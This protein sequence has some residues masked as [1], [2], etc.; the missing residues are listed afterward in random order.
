MKKKLIIVFIILLFSV[1]FHFCNKPGKIDLGNFPDTWYFLEVQ[2]HTG[3]AVFNLSCNGE[4]SNI[5]IKNVNDSYQ[6]IITDLGELIEQYEIRSFGLND[7]NTG[8]MEVRDPDREKHVLTF[9]FPADDHYVFNF[10]SSSEKPLPVIASWSLDDMVMGWYVADQM[11]DVIEKI[12]PPCLECF[13]FDECL[14][15]ISNPEKYIEMIN[16]AIDRSFDG[17]TVKEKTETD[18]DGFSGTDY[19]V[20]YWKGE[21]VKVISSY[22]AGVYATELD[23]FYI[24]NKNL[25]ASRHSYNTRPMMEDEKMTQE[26]SK[27]YYRNGMPLKVERKYVEYMP[28]PGENFDP[29]LSLPGFDEAIF[30]SIEFNPDVIGKTMDRKW[31]KAEFRVRGSDDND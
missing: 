9:E 5:E 19:R 14:V 26:E 6:L 31:R 1:P 8:M 24:K 30:N 3:N 2:D 27:I 28:E 20:Y 13:D 7:D 16:H 11:P 21:A 4:S 18:M 17:I 23:V 15:R 12:H 10:F 22:S 25:L 29:G